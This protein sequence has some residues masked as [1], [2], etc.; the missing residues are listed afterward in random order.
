MCDTLCTFIPSTKGK[1]VLFA[2]N[3][4]RSPN[5]PH[6]VIRVPEK[7]YADGEQVKLTYITIPQARHTLAA[8]LCKPSWT[9]GA[10]MGVNEAS[11]A[12]G[13]EAVFT[14]EKRGQEAL[15][16][17][18]LVR[19]ALERC[20]SAANAV[21]LIASLLEKYG[22]G[23]NCGFDHTFYYDNSFLIVD[24]REGYVIETAGKKWAADKISGCRAISNRLTI[25][26]EHQTRSG[27]DEDFDFAGRLT[28]PLFTF[29]SGS[30]QRLNSTCHS[31]KKAEGVTEMMSALRAHYPKDEKKVFTH[32][33][34]R[35]VCMHAGGKVG[36]QTTGSLVAVLRED[37]PST[38][39]VTG[40]STPCIS[41]FKPVF[42]ELDTGEPVFTEESAA[43]NYWLQRES[44]HRGVLSGTIDP[45]EIKRHRNILEEKWIAQEH[46]LF[47]QDTPDMD[48]LKEF[49]EKASLE[50][51]NFIKQFSS[52]NS[53]SMPQKGRFNQYWINKNALLEKMR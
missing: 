21:D 6:L 24:P 5:E 28:E 14:K 20:G 37:R 41:L 42:L 18:D 33:S 2:K 43:K 47:E 25:H 51:S 50:E 30:R 12:I 46:K 45:T 29:F 4:D 27:V 13:N 36:D 9:W 11:V 49:A 16:G 52:N 8:I 10:E 44:I 35:S 48:K 31:L 15:I 7:D 39:W 34:I 3:S 22:Q 53:W 32:G 23:G 38:L 17:M 19:L 40:S 1:A 26:K